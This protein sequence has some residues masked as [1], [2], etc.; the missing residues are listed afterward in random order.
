MRNYFTRV[1]IYTSEL[2][3]REAVAIIPVEFSVKGGPKGAERKIQAL[4]RQDIPKRLPEEYKG[5][6]FMLGSCSAL[7]DSIDE[8]PGSKL[9][10]LERMKF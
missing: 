10:E 5:P 6:E 7:Y 4:L 1:T 9:P 3:T 2:V 8:V